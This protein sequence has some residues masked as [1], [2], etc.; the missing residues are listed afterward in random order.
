MYVTSLTTYNLRGPYS[1]LDPRGFTPPHALPGHLLRRVGKAGR[2]RAAALG[3]EPRALG[4]R[5]KRNHRSR[6]TS[7]VVLRGLVDQAE[8][9][10]VD[11]QL[12]RR[13]PDRLL[14]AAAPPRI[15]RKRLDPGVLSAHA[16]GV[17]LDR[18]PDRHDARHRA[19]I[20]HRRAWV[21]LEI[22]IYAAGAARRRGCVRRFA[23][24]R[25]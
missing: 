15:D 18:S 9:D 17:H 24:A 19:A 5:A 22:R 13:G 3:G 7:P 1:G 21:G 10:Q 2:L 14:L 20:A 16:L 23:E 11:S 4:L 12:V 6:Q 8:I 25:I